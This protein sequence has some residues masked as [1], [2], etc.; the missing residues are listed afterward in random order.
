MRT[1]LCTI[2]WPTLVTEIDYEI[3]KQVYNENCLIE[4]DPS[5]MIRPACC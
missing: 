2:D 1:Y 5:L 4:E 3:G